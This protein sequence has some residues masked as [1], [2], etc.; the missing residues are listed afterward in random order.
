MACARC[1]RSLWIR[2]VAETKRDLQHAFNKVEVARLIIWQ[3]RLL[4][5]LHRQEAELSVGAEFILRSKKLVRRYV[6]AVR[7]QILLIR[8][9]IR[10]YISQLAG[11]PPPIQGE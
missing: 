1:D 11:L 2:L 9:S 3:L 4:R 10:E 7:N 5:S 6:R 8:E